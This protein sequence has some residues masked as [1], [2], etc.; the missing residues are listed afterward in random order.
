MIDWIESNYTWILILWCLQDFQNNFYD[1]GSETWPTWHPSG[2]IFYINNLFSSRNEK[3]EIFLFH[4]KLKDNRVIIG[5]I[6]CKFCVLFDPINTVCW[7]NFTTHWCKADKQFIAKIF[8]KLQKRFVQEQL[9]TE[10]NYKTL[11]VSQN[12]FHLMMKYIQFP[13]FDQK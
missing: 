4:G 9:W 13:M 5:S 1:A 11:L 8:T 7:H 6:C 12:Q 3:I 2:I 10:E